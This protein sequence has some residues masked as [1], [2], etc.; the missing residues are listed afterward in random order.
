MNKKALALLAILIFSTG[1]L[2]AQV[3]KQVKQMA[4][5]DAR[6][7][8]FVALIGEEEMQLQ[9]ISLK[10]MQSGEQAKLTFDELLAKLQ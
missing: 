5:A 3:S 9:L 8:P 7:I 4:Y 1:V 2:H 10:D 6:K